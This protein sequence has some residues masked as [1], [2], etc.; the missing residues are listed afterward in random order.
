MLLATGTND[1]GPDTYSR[2]ASAQ[3]ASAKF[4]NAFFQIVLQRVKAWDEKYLCNCLAE[5]I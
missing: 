3:I 2:F 5:I 1:F 4:S